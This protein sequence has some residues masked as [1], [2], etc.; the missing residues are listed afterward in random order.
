MIAISCMVV[1]KKDSNTKILKTTKTM[2]NL[3]KIQVIGAY[4]KTHKVVVTAKISSEAEV[5]AVVHSI[6]NNTKTL[7]TLISKI[8]GAVDKFSTK[9]HKNK[10]VEHQIGAI[11]NTKER[12]TKVKTT[13]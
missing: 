1:R 13:P 8:I 5:E 3:T 7:N 6:S 9:P 4:A 10:K 12:Q 11:I 2:T